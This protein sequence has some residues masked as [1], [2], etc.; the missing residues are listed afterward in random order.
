MNSSSN[1]PRPIFARLRFWLQDRQTEKQLIEHIIETVEPKIRLASG[2]RKQ[3]RR[4][5]Q[6][7]LE[8]CKAMVAS[9]PG[10]IHLKKSDYDAD[11]LIHAAFI[12]TVKLKDLIENQDTTL[13]SPIPAEPDRYALLTMTHRETTIFGPKIQG[14]MIQG[15]TQMKSVTF[16]DHK[17]VGL[18]TTLESSRNRLEQI[19]FQMI[20]E[21]V[22]RALATKRTDLGEL[23]EHLE[24][25]HA[26]SHIFAG[27]NHAQNIFGHSCHEDFEKLKKVAQMLEESED[28]LVRARQGYE[29][30]EDWLAILIEHLIIPK[31]IMHIQRISMRLDW[32]NVLTEASEEKANNITLVQ[33]L[34][35]DKIKRDAVF[36]CY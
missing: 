25:L 9:I 10:P 24:R 29:T 35:A 14:D 26:M 8:H 12:G 2:Y 36:I 20:L 31:K 13:I 1:S 30:P 27:G 32:R 16:T 3:L 33:C 17:I 18:F 34:L 5:I 22:S 7:G 23:R 6:I 19:C 28:E 4:P 11:P 15:D 21:A